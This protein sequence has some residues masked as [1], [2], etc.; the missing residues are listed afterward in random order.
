VQLVSTPCRFGGA[1]WW[2]ICPATGR[3]AVKLYLPNG[4]QRFL[5]RQAYQLAYA[6]QAEDRIMR[7]Y[8]SA[9]KLQQRLGRSSYLRTC[10]FGLPPKPKFMRWS[11]Y[12]RLAEQLWATDADIAVALEQQMEAI[13][14]QVTRLEEMMKATSPPP[15]G[16]ALGDPPA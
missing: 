7:A 13:T 9:A 11:T 15:F 10:F 3:R 5:S 8:R 2:F 14:A 4:G 16:A 6:S 1:R 12:I